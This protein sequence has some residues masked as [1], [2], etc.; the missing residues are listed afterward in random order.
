MEGKDVITVI[1]FCDNFEYGTHR[2]QKVNYLKRHFLER[3]RIYKDK[4]FPFKNFKVK[5]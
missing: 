1:D 3:Q 5:F 4:G 2:F